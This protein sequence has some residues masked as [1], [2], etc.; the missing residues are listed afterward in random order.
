VALLRWNLFSHKDL[1]GWLDNP[2][3]HPSD[4]QEDKQ[5]MLPFDSFGQ[6]MKMAT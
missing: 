5:I 1:W 4:P 6:H 2:Y 3:Y